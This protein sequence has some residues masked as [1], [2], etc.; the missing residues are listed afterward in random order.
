MAAGPSPD[1]LRAVGRSL[2]LDV[3]GFTTAEPFADTRRVLEERKEAGL[4]G[5]MQF[6]Y[7]NPARSTDPTRTMAGARTLV[8]GAR[9]YLRRPPGDVGAGDRPAGRRPGGRVARYAWSD[10]YGPL[11][12]G[13]GGI[14]E[15]LRSSGH[16]AMVLA[17]DNALVDRA[18]AVRA[19]L[20]WYGN[21]TTVLIPGM[22]SWYVIGA[23]LTDAVLA[24]D[25]LTD[26][27]LV[28]DGPGDPAADEPPTGSGRRVNAAV[29]AGCGPCRRC[30]PACP[31]GAI[32]SPGVLD[33]RRCLAWLVQAPGVLPAEYREAVGDRIYGCDDCQDVCPVNRIGERRHPPAEAEPEAEPAVDVLELLAASDDEILARWGRWYIAE[34]RPRYLR[35]NALIVL[36]N[37]GDPKDPAVLSAVAAA[38]AADDGLLRAHAVWAAAR[39]GR[40]DL[41]AGLAGDPDPEV[42]AEVASIDRVGVRPG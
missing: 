19:G 5:G 27:G 22:G 42:R 39:L 3:V 23:V 6:T 28:D 1:E 40:P 20:G 17:D 15:R 38:L 31:T 13:L 33:A 41:A 37:T 25:V 9:R 2:G 30:L 10:Y 34:R 18:A 24:D 21:N 36:G 29:T 16:R 35:R 32:V 12:D 7:R 26:D 8:V 4:H 11:R 14:A